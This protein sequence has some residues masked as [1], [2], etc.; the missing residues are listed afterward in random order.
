VRSE[1]RF[2]SGGG[3]W[4]VLAALVVSI[5]AFPALLAWRA[6]SGGG[7]LPLGDSLS[8]LWAD[9]A[10]G[11]RP[12]GLEVFGPADP[13]AAVVALLG[14]LTPWSP[15]TALVALWILALRLAVL[16]GWFAAT[17]V[18]DRAGLRIVG[19]IAWALAP[20]FLTSLV[21]GRP[22]A[23]I[24][25]LL[26]PWLFYTAGIA[27]RSW[28]AAGAASLLLVAVVACAPQL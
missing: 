19:G 20:T 21:D 23:V 2:F 15:S 8:R 6:L 16:G 12:T 14:S 28:G 7:I 13:F 1:L 25:H 26:L 24:A 5:A 17:R 22:P 3:A 18:T 27:H 11:L 4:V 9:A 10:Y